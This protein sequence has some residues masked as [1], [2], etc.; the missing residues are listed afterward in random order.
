MNATNTYLKKSIAEVNNFLKNSTDPPMDMYENFILELEVSTLILP[1][2]YEG[3]QFVFPNIKTDDGKLLLPVFTDI[4]E[5]NKYLDDEYE[6]IEYDFTFYINL[7][8]ELELDGIVI[9]CEGVELVIDSELLEK[10]PHLPLLPFCEPLPPQKLIEISKTVKNEE[11]LNFI[12]H[13]DNFNN[14]DEIK[15]LLKSSTLLNVAVSREDLSEY[16]HDGII[17]SLD[18]G[19]FGLSAIT[20][21]KD[22]YVPMF[23]DLDSIKKTLDV[24]SAY[25]YLQVSTLLVVVKYVLMSDLEGIMLNPGLEEY[26][27]PR[28]VLLRMFNDKDLINEDLAAG[29]IYAFEI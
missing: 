3:E 5:Y 20:V 25:Y 18:V 9:D 24:E 23:T 2:F 21:G 8:E 7:V 19:G 17:E 13:E 10:I 11:L 26:I 29:H 4:D 22:R 6:P 1:G 16:V 28:N 27:V 15:E 14:S 12:R